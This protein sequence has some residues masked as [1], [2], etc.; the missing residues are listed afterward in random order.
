MKFIAAFV[1]A[2]FPL[3]SNPHPST[4]LLH[5]LS[6]PPPPS[7]SKKPNYSS[8]SLSLTHSLSHSLTHSLSPREWCPYSTCALLSAT[9]LFFLSV[10]LASRKVLLIVAYREKTSLSRRDASCVS[11]FHEFQAGR[12]TLEIGDQ[13][14]FLK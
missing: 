7:L 14:L 3:T 1:Y 10:S 6:S 9:L 11:R 4:L 8:P 5:Y 12:W 2:V 13:G